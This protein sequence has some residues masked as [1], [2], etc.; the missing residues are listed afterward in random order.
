MVNSELVATLRTLSKQE[1]KKLEQFLESPY[2]TGKKDNSRALLLVRAIFGALKKGEKGHSALHREALFDSIF[3]KKK[4]FTGP[5]FNRLT[6][7][8][9]DWTRT[10]IVMEMMDRQRRPVLDHAQLLNFFREKGEIDLSEK[11]FQ[12]LDRQIKG[13]AQPDNLDF[14]HKW[15]AEAAKTFYLGTKSGHK[16]DFNMRQSLLAQKEY[17]L[18]EYLETLTALFN[19]NRFTPVLSKEAIQ[20]YLAE[21][22]GLDKKPKSQTPIILLSRKVLQ[23]MH[24]PPTKAEATFREFMDLLALHQKDLALEH[25]KRMEDF[26]Y[27]FCTARYINPVYKKL[28]SELHRRRLQPERLNRER[29]ILALEL[30]SMV[31]L[32]LLQGQYE[33]VESLIHTFKNRILGPASSEKHYLLCLAMLYA[34]TNRLEAAHDIVRNLN[35]HDITYRYHTKA[36]EI[37]LIYD[38]M[39]NNAEYLES[40]LN[41]YKVT[42]SR[43]IAL[44]E[45]RLLLYRNFGNFMIR[46][47]H[48]RQQLVPDWGHLQSIRE[49]LNQLEPVHDKTWMQEKIQELFQQ[50]PPGKG[51]PKGDASKP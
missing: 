6:T 35:F 15:Q 26:A 41:S 11:Y 37:R 30:L 43:E 9:L 38:W 36:L 14:F 2:C 23:F 29:H 20:A 46:I 17:F 21:I 12:R 13:K 4:K 31:K 3:G 44:H 16:D 48:W 45:H 39:P 51:K 50:K 10:F 7:E 22:D 27:N 24:E 5:I 32:G 28:L 49:E 25:L 18:I 8:T 19:L 47:N 1:Q 33:L 42:L 34:Y 40:K